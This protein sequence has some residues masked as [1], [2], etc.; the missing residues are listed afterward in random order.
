MADG[1]PATVI[2]PCEISVRS[3]DLMIN[4]DVLRAALLS[5]FLGTTNRLANALNRFLV[6]ILNLGI[7][8][9]RRPDELTFRGLEQT[10]REHNVHAGLFALALPV[11]ITAPSFVSVGSSNLMSLRYLA[12]PVLTFSTPACLSATPSRATNME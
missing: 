6:V 11:T 4:D 9:E 5:N 8:D 1:G 10:S 12:S 3:N 7:D 2:P